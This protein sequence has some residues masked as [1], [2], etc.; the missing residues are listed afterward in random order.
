M[1]A[2]NSKGFSNPAF[3]QRRR[4]A[5]VGKVKGMIVEGMGLIPL[6]IIPLSFWPLCVEL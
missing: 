4:D 2:V 6:T 5:K 3:T 1:P